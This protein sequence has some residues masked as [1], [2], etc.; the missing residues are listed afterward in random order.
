[1]DSDFKSEAKNLFQKWRFHTLTL[2]KCQD[3]IKIQTI[4]SQTTFFYPQKFLKTVKL[5]EVNLVHSEPLVLLS[6]V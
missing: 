4:A 6:K 1:M 5:I 2:M 3:L